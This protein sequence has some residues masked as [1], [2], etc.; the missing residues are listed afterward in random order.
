MGGGTYN[1]RKNRRVEPRNKEPDTTR[2]PKPNQAKNHRLHFTHL[3]TSTSTYQSS[4]TPNERAHLPNIPIPS[5]L[6]P[7]QSQLYHQTHPIN[8]PIPILTISQYFPDIN[9]N[10]ELHLMSLKVIKEIYSK[11]LKRISSSLQIS[12]TPMD[13][14]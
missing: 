1:M 7:N 6:Q 11:T 5:N 3:H 12:P 2:I 10:P 14:W 8:I 9:I 13:S 4:A